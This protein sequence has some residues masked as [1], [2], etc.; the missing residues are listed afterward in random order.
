MPPQL[1]KR[2][3][4]KITSTKKTN[5]TTKNQTP[6]PTTP[7]NWSIILYGP[8]GIGKTSLCA[9]LPNVA[10]VVDKR[11]RGILKLSQRNIVPKPQSIDVAR[12]WAQLLT[13][14]DPDNFSE[15]IDHVVIESITGIESL[16]F[17]HICR[18]RHNS[19]WRSFYDYHRG[20]I[21]AGN[22]EWP[23][24]MDALAELEDSGKNIVLTGHSKT[25]NEKNPA[26]DDYTKFQVACD[27][28]T[29]EK[30]KA[31]EGGILFYNSEVI[32][33]KKAKGLRTK[34]LDRVQREIFCTYS[35]LWD[36]KNWFGLPD[37]I[38]AGHSP[39]ESARNLL[40]AIK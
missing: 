21:S 31:W 15:D 26:G 19:D 5:S 4:K 30:L 35:P 23:E 32:P 17:E 1:K 27:G 20:P 22:F 7:I 6:S 2:T 12:S 33:D 9:H 14:L 37:T 39:E 16:C 25:G 38:E 3:A 18:E 28:R 13:K 29:W 24:F 8:Q 34:V 40:E 36:S 10:F 11:E